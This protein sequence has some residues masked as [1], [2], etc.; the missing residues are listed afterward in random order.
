MQAAA[1]EALGAECL[2]SHCHECLEI[3]D[4]CVKQFW[5]KAFRIVA[6][7]AA[8]RVRASRAVL[9][10]LGIPK[11]ACSGVFI[12]E[13]AHSVRGVALHLQENGSSSNLY[14]TNGQKASDSWAY[15]RIEAGTYY[16][17]A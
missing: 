1:P 8:I 15:G 11:G 2:Y 10:L 9:L 6:P 17:S 14:T 16:S 13:N 5:P 12:G 3:P 4:A 7:M